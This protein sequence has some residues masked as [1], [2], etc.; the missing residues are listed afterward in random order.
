[1]IEIIRRFLARFCFPEHAWLHQNDIIA[2]RTCANCGRHEW[3]FLQSL[4]ANR[5]PA[6]IWK[7]MPRP[8][9]FNRRARPK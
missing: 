3:K 9:E 7:R 4:P 6:V 1:M 2:K 5:D 8:I